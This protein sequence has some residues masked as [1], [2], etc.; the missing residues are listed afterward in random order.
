MAEVG[1]AEHASDGNV[2]AEIGKA[3]EAGAEKHD[4]AAAE[5][6]EVVLPA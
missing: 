3:Y 1:R 4:D 6:A 2:V 5:Y